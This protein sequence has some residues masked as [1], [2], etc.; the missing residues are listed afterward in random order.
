MSMKIINRLLTLLLA[1]LPMAVFGQ[2]SSDVKKQINSIKK[3]NQY[4][5]ADVTAATE[6]DAHDLAEDELNQNINE[7]A[8]TKKKLRDSQNFIVSNKRELWAE[9]KMPRGNMFRSFM[10]VKKSDIQGADNV[11]VID[12]TKSSA[13]AVSGSQIEN[14]VDVA[15]PGTVSEL[16]ACT[17]YSDFV[18]LLKQKSADG[19]VSTYGRYASLD[20]PD[21][22]YL[23]IYDRQGNMKAMLTQAP[24][25]VNAAT[26]KL[27]DVTNYRGCGAIGFKL[28]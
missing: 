21:D 10:Y 3:N 28:R 16:M 23:A 1:L 8:A 20:N 19:S 5:Y 6:Q 13:P 2:N 11:D 7:W 22:Y 12:N 17:K 14:I 27:D 24:N 15:I 26:K 18:N 9:L 4:I 25:R